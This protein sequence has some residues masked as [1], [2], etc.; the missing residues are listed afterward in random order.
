MGR[1]RAVVVAA[2][3]C[4]G[5]ALVAACGGTRTVGG[6]AAELVPATAPVF[7]AIDSDP[8]SSQWKTVDELANRFPDKAEAVQ[9][10]K[11]DLREDEGLD[12]DKDVK[13]ALGPE[14]DVVWL[15]LENDGG[16]VVGLTQPADEDAFERLVD[17][18]NA[19]D[20]DEKLYYERVDEWVAFSDSQALVDRFAKESR[21]AA[22][23]LADDPAF[24]R[25][26]DAFADESLVRAYVS[27]RQVMDVISQYDPASKDVLLQLGTLE[28][29]G[30]A[31]R[32]TS[33]GVRFDTVVRG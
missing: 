33:D 20:P 14:I 11:R 27:G 32:V 13:P 9:S 18:G 26:M 24:Q 31:L 30:A 6:G 17:K 8:E 2:A 16:N 1:V 15:D 5:V 22:D 25:G 3:L 28:W 4:C 7:I 23:K 19:R 12:F 29:L 10:L 21:S